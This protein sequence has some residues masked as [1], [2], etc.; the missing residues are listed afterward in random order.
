L[1][2]II[3]VYYLKMAEWLEYPSQWLL[4][5]WIYLDLLGMQTS[6]LQSPVVVVVVEGV[7]EEEA[8]W[9]LPHATLPDELV[10]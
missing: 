6:C 2:H 7:V 4:K 10:S 3:L 8:I 9:V 5:D 1:D